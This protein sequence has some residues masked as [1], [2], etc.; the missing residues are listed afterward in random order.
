M[1]EDLADRITKALPGPVVEIIEAAGLAASQSRQRLYLVG[2]I[3]RDLLLQRESRDIDIMAGRDAIALAGLMSTSPGIKTVTHS[4]FGT[5]T[6]KM[7]DYR[8]DLAT[9]RSESYDHPGALPRVKPGTIRQDLFRRDF[10]VNA[11]AACI[12]PKHFGEV[13]DLY[14]GLQDLDERII[15]ILHDKSFADDATRIM[16]AV[17]YEQR[18]GFK[19]ERRTARLL[20]RDLDMLDNISGDRLRH[21]VLLWLSEPRPGRVLRRASALGILPKLHH[22]LSWNPSLGR[23]FTYAGRAQGEFPPVPLYFALLAY[24]LQKR[25]LEQLLVRLNIKGGDL[26]EISE[27]TLSLKNNHK[28]HEEAPLQPSGIYQELKSFHPIA[29]RANELLSPHP[30]VRSNLKLYL[31]RLRN[32]KPHMTGNDLAAIGVPRGKKMGLILDRLLTARL[33]GK[34]RTKGDEEKLA[35]HWL[36]AL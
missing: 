22:A 30:A 14:G 18:L 15:R 13:I 19:L 25:Q 9:C 31:T 24:Q 32:V 36:A 11:L 34:V 5:A 7:G 3:V 8:L 35:G 21:E 10:T 17:R 23:A 1:R 12:N 28:L 2:G 33:D 26:K 16:R 20:R 4:A 6:I 29:I 27:Q